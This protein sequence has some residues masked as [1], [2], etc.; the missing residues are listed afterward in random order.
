MSAEPEAFNGAKFS[1]GPQEGPFAIL[2]KIVA[3][4]NSSERC[5]DL[6]SSETEDKS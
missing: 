2:K 3:R 4:V 1:N 5:Q 6:I